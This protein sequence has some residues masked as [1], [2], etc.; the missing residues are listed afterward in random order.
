MGNL[1]V[2]GGY[3][4]KIDPL[5]AIQGRTGVDKAWYDGLLKKKGDFSLAETLEIR[6]SNGLGFIVKAGQIFRIVQSHGPQ[7]C[8]MIMFN[9]H[10]HEERSDF[11]NS[12]AFEGL[13]LHKYTRIWSSIPWMRP[14]ATIIDDTS[15]YS[16]IPVGFVYHMWGPHCCTEWYELTYGCRNHNSCHMNFIQALEPFGMGEAE[17]RL[18]NMNLFQAQTLEATENREIIPR[19]SPTV[20]DIG[21][22]LELYAEIDL[23]VVISNCPYGDQS[24]SVENAVCHPLTI[25]IY[26]T[27]VAPRKARQWHDWR[28]KTNLRK[29]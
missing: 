11:G 26:N 6:P 8:D 22:Y 27:G 28:R 24:R 1:N 20:T 19:L 29:E 17:A 9:R 10:C 25:E 18:P 5:T 21:D 23:I 7:I 2:N 12:M 3:N 14:M 15:D 16:K 13:A 4:E